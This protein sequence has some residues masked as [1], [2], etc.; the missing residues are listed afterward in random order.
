MSHGS[1]CQ[2]AEENCP[3]C[4]V[5]EILSDLLITPDVKLCTVWEEKVEIRALLCRRK[6]GRTTET[7]RASWGAQRWS[8][9]QICS[10]NEMKLALLGSEGAGKSG[11]CFISVFISYAFKNKLVE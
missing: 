2:F 3:K 4:G 1:L 10:M 7:Q 8:V 11:L 5:C 6:G 9:G